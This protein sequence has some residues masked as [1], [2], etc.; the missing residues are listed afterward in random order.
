MMKDIYEP[1]HRPQYISR[2]IVAY[3]LDVLV[4]ISILFLGNFLHFV[5]IDLQLESLKSASASLVMIGVM[6]CILYMVCKDVA[7][8][9][10]IGKRSM[11]LI[12]LQCKDDQVC[13]KI[14][15]IIRNLLLQIPGLVFIEWI[16]L[17][18]KDRRIGD[19]LVGSYVADRRKIKLEQ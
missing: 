15:S 11:K 14:R 18:F 17:F 6:W 2:R 1:G 4:G 8:G 13:G 19:L 10:S 16:I 3:I 9:S 12:I 7:G 5:A